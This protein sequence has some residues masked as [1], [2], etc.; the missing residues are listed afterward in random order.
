[1]TSR[2]FASVAGPKIGPEPSGVTNQPVTCNTFELAAFSSPAVAPARSLEQVP[3]RS[4]C[5]SARQSPIMT[6]RDGLECGRP[7]SVASHAL[8]SPLLSNYKSATAR[9]A[10]LPNRPPLP[11]QAA[12]GVARGEGHHQ[13][14]HL[15]GMVSRYYRGMR[16]HP[17][18]GE[19]LIALCIMAVKKRRMRFCLSTTAMRRVLQNLKR[20]SPTFKAIW[21]K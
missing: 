14:A 3:R 13:H 4:G 19:T 21:W 1:V 6:A 5:M 16:A 11:L 20:P 18:S 12:E 2:A 9:D 7:A 15:G 17:S 8:R 10:A